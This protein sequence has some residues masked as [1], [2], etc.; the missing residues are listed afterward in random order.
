MNRPA[1]PPYKN[2]LWCVSGRR[3]DGRGCYKTERSTPNFTIF[4][5]SCVPTIQNCPPPSPF[6]QPLLLGPNG[7]KINKKII[8]F[9][10]S[11]CE[12]I[13]ADPTRQTKVQSLSTQQV[14]LELLF[15]PLFW[16][17]FTQIPTKKIGRRGSPMIKNVLTFRYRR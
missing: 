2:I 15:I 7:P 11:Q 3:M 9:F 14:S 12:H 13:I 8:L 16:S 5:I 4:N 10:Y 17:Y 6:Q 1:L